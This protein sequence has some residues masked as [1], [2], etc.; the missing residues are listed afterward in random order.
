[1]RWFSPCRGLQSGEYSVEQEGAE[2]TALGGSGVEHQST[3]VEE[4]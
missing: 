2:L 4:V 1:M 3:R